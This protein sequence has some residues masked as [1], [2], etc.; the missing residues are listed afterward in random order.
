MKNN[1]DKKSGGPKRTGPALAAVDF[2]GA[3]ARALVAEVLPDQS[4][5]LLGV[6][7][8]PARGIRE[9]RVV[10]IEEATA[11]LGNAIKEA[12]I[13]SNYRVQSV[14][15]AVSGEHLDGADASGSTVISEMSV[16]MSDISK[17]KAM[18][19]AEVAHR[20]GIKVIATLDRDYQ[21][22]GQ[23]GIHQPLGMSGHKLSGD[24]HLI[25][26]SSNALSDMEK[27]LLQCGASIEQQFIFAGLAA[28]KSVLSKDEKQLGVCVADIGAGTTDVVVYSQGVVWQ[29]FSFAMASDDIHSDIAHMHH[30]SLD[31]AERAKKQIG[32]VGDGG[33]FISLFDAGGSGES[34]QSMPVVRDTI[35]HRVDEILET[36]GE[37]LEPFG[38]EH[39]LSGGLVLVGDGALLPGIA[40]AAAAK[41][42]MPTRVGRPRYRGQNHEI[43]ASPRFAVGIGLLEMAAV[44]HRDTE[45]VRRQE[46]IWLRLTNW[47]RDTF[48]DKA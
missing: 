27:C 46:N 31:S 9:G 29:T 14:W 24:V 13:M 26:A 44:Y 39:P 45:R 10:N 47:L 41:L 2:G 34:R 8:V 18:A 36:I 25:L 35:S 28:A 37:K 32:V 20:P 5:R 43:V 33:E 19:R 4:L 11:T 40:E 7:E 48:A 38:G 17:V 42:N 1:E 23:T 21:L 16:S 6:G 15:P 30:A 3:A 12:E 22:D